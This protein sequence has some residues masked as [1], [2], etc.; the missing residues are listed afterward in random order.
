MNG[1]L[2]TPA[3]DKHVTIDGLRMR[4]LEE[5]S[6]HPVLLMHGASLGSSADVFRRHLR[7]LAEA[8]LRPIAFDLP[9]YGSSEVGGDLSTAYQLTAME[10]FADALGLE[11]PALIAHS[12]SGALAVQLALR[13]PG[14][15]SHIVALGTNLLLPPL[16]EEV[17]GRDARLTQ[18][19]DRR[20]TATEPTLADTKKLMEADL[21]HTELVTPEELALR[22]RSSIGKPFEV[23]AQR[24]N[25]GELA[26][27]AG[28]PLWRKMFE[29]KI[30]LQ[31]IIG[32]DDRSNACERAE[33][34]MKMHPEVNL[35]LVPDCKHMVP[36]D[37]E[38]EVYRLTIPFIK[39][40]AAKRPQSV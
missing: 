29:L 20:L 32:R 12:R 19:I 25:A 10:K 16:T 21:F 11:T 24:A 36:W 27:P 37:A 14:R 13:E 17:E 7:P 22:H 39:G 4:Y 3:A 2:A 34:L 35:H 15:Y 1:H 38:R 31:L 33:L 8:G 6:G 28:E 18:R 9:G 26:P 30:P 40:T 23:F 5:G